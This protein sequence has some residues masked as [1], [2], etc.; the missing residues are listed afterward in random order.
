MR[1]VWF[2][3]GEYKRLYGGHLKHSD[4]VRHVASMPG[5]MSR[6]TFTGHAGNRALENERLALWPSELCPHETSWVPEK[7][8]VLF[9]AGLDWRYVLEGGYDKLPNPRINLIQG[10]R[11]AEPDTELFEYLALRAVRICVSQEVADEIHATGR[12]NGPVIAIPNGLTPHSI[13]SAPKRL[14]VTIVG[15][16]DPELAQALANK[17]A[18]NGIELRLL[19]NFIP[20]DC[21]LTLLSRSRVVVC[22]PKAQEGFYLPPLEAMSF[23]CMVVTVDCVGNR[24]FC[25]HES[26][27]LIARRSASSLAEATLR[28]LNSGAFKGWL[29]RRKASSTAREHSLSKERSKFQSIIKGIDRIWSSTAGSN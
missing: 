4:Y 16:K 1:T 21:F 29:Q 3:R 18:S 8:D 25:V 19:M 13:V 22:I 15:Y 7:G 24:S 11:H 2:H 5:F 17:L 12:V 27:C 20:R 10:V 23:G 9:L 28:A 14:P 6:I 26:N